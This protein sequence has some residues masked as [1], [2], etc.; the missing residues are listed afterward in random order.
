MELPETVRR[1]HFSREEQILLAGQCE[2]VMLDA[3]DETIY[4][5]GASRLALDA[6]GRPS[7]SYDC[8]PR[9][10]A[11]EFESSLSESF[12]MMA[13]NDTMELKVPY[14]E[15]RSSSFP[16]NGIPPVP[17][18]PGSSHRHRRNFSTSRSF[19]VGS[20]QLNHHRSR[21]SISTRHSAKASISTVDQEAAY[22][23][24]PE[25]R[26][27]LRV[28]LASPQKFDEAVEF[29]FPASAEDTRSI[30]VAAKSLGSKRSHESS[31]KTAASHEMED[32]LAD[33]GLSE[34]EDEDE[35]VEDPATPNE[36]EHGFPI[37]PIPQQRHNLFSEGR[38]D[39]YIHVLSGN[40]EMTLRMT[41]TRP[42]LR[43]DE[44]AIYGWQSEIYKDN[45][46][47]PV[48]ECVKEDPLALDDLPVVSEDDS[49]C[50][51]LWKTGYG[52]EKGLKGL[53]RRV[54]K[55]RSSSQNF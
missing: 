40:R 16:G 17:A 55:S 11:S 38:H 50:T 41:L 3:A 24:D 4:R 22:Y 8:S 27:K 33:D 45:S 14:K 18:L 49:G 15:A 21:P 37:S 42:D 2:S 23:Q 29:G 12:K 31:T 36:F 7:S 13:Y 34:E 5:L 30:T 39:P 6:S 48:L 28:Y 47:S 54:V 10:D 43:A 32:L 51:D 20:P 19:S 46:N 44:S 1:K 35:V 9:M 53:W 52:N 25:T 26:L